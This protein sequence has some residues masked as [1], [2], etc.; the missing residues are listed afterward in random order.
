[1]N[2]STMGGIAVNHGKEDFEPAWDDTG[3]G[4]EDHTCTFVDTTL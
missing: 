3:N 1:M 2:F 4:M